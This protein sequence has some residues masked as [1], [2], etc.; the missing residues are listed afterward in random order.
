[1]GISTKRMA[2]LG[3]LGGLKGGRIRADQLSSRRRAEIARNAATARWSRRV[4]LPSS[5]SQREGLVAFVAHYGS[6]AHGRA[7]VA[8]VEDRIAQAIEASHGDAA[9]ARMLP[10]L[11]WRLRSELDLRKLERAAE[12]RGE[13]RALGFFL[14]LTAALAS[15]LRQEAAIHCFEEAAQSLLPQARGGEP[16]YFFA[17]TER[18]P[19]ERLAADEN[20][21][22]VA[23][24]WGLLLNMPYA[25]F[26]SHFHRCASL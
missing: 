25:S 23:K 9:M 3:R 16:A 14:D 6:V 11:L 2:A 10:V 17:G 19:F 26:E 7:A 13:T 8:S 18:R 12:D 22:G 4:V 15:G 5:L 1:M 21:P 24:R 20:T